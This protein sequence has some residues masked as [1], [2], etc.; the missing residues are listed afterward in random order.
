MRE[1]D[2][3]SV[4]LHFC[5]RDFFGALSHDILKPVSKAQTAFFFGL[6]LCASQSNV[7]AVDRVSV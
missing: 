5:L 3:E 7:Q 4:C 2:V 1:Q 6:G